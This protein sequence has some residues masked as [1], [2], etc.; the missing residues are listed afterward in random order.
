MVAT[1]ATAVLLEV[2]L[3]VAVGIAFPF[4][5]FATTLTAGSTVVLYAPEL[6][7]AFDTS[8]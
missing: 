6:F 5:S 3:I 4:E 8:V 1:V 7:V 2:T